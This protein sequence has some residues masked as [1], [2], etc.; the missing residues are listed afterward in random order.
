[1]DGEYFVKYSHL[2]QRANSNEIR[3]EAKSSKGEAQRVLIRQFEA[4]LD[5]P[6]KRAKT[7]LCFLFSQQYSLAWQAIVITS[8]ACAVQMILKPG[9]T[10][11]FYPGEQWDKSIK[12]KLAE[13]DVFILLLSAD[14]I[15][16][17]LYLGC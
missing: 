4:L 7:R 3:I 17:R 10:K 9:M 1:M 5:N 8:L 11:R 12:S 15:A 2:R 16:S 14:F 6:P 13:A